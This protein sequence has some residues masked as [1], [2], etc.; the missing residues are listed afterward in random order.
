MANVTRV[1]GDAGGVVNVDI[2]SHDYGY[3]TSAN[4]IIA[5]G[6]T[7]HPTAYNIRAN[8]ALD[9]G[10]LS[11]TEAILRSLQTAATVVM[12]QLGGNA[13]VATEQLNVLVEAQGFGSDANVLAALGGVFYSNVGTPISVTSVSSTNGFRLQ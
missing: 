2:S 3:T 9:M 11:A 13:T 8:A 4:V 7:K 1:N 12:Y 6:L 5:T 10:T